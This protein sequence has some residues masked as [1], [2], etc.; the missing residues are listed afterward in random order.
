MKRS[1]KQSETFKRRA[2]DLIEKIEALINKMPDKGNSSSES[3]KICLQIAINDF[4][5]NVNGVEPSD[6]EEDKD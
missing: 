4:S 2:E 1:Q 6:F 3:Q 5:H